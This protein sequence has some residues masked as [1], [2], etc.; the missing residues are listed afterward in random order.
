MDVIKTSENEWMLDIEDIVPDSFSE[1]CVP[2]FIFFL[3]GFGDKP[4]ME[5][6]PG[7][8]SLLELLKFTYCPVDDPALLLFKCAP[9]INNLQCYNLVSG[10]LDET[11]ELII[12]EVERRSPRDG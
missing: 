6:L 12:N 5:K 7:S 11:T 9:L 10:S 8:A 4:R 2:H 1:T 3:R